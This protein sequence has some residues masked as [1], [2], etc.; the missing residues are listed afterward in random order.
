MMGLPCPTPLSADLL[1]PKPDEQ[2][3]DPHQNHHLDHQPIFVLDHL[4]ISGKILV[5]TS[6]QIKRRKNMFAIVNCK[7]ACI[8]KSGLIVN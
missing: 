3:A 5:Q 7:K 6:F 4:K 1:M 8:L 2:D